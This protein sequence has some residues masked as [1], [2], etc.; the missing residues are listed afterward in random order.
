MGNWLQRLCC[1]ITKHKL[2]KGTSWTI[3][4]EPTEFYYKCLI[5][6]KTFWNYTPHRKYLKTLKEEKVGAEE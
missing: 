4:I 3:G 1:K 2:R 6:G 5:C